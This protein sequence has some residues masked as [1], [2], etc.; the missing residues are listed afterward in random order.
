M[1]R[2]KSLRLVAAVIVLVAVASGAYAS[3]RWWSDHSTA[4]SAATQE[5]GAPATGVGSA[6]ETG[7]VT[8]PPRATPE[9]TLSTFGLPLGYAAWSACTQ[10]SFA[11]AGDGASAR[12]TYTCRGLM[13]WE[14]WREALRRSAVDLGWR[15]VA[16]DSEVL[17]FVQ[18]DL[19]VAMTIDP[20]PLGAAFALTQRPLRS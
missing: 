7:G 14:A 18:D 10:I 2:R 4:G 12:W 19:R 3:A 5:N 6:T 20:R 13:T 1:A 9:A 15:E 8:Y 16:S 17:E 11:R